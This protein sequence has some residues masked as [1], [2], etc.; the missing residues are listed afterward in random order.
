M[1]LNLY[2]YGVCDIGCKKPNNEDM[3]LLHDKMFRDGKLHLVFDAK[4]RLVFAVADGVGGL[5]KGEVASEL[6]LTSLRDILEKIPGDLS[7]E[8]LREVFNTY[9][10]ETHAK[11]NKD[12][13]ST[14]VGLFIYNDKLFRF[15]AGDSRIYRLRRGELERLTVDHSLC[16]S[17]GQKDAPSNII[18]NSIGG[19]ASSFIEFAEIPFPFFNNDIYLLSSDGMHDLVSQEEITKVLSNSKNAAEKLVELAKK[20]GGKD[21]ISVVIINIKEK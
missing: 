17:G 1:K 4:K 13:G 19:G 15:H 18:T 20:Y 12:M 5:N 2:A 11:L 7:N 16:E 9:T 3:V 21:N 8:E 6:V 10:S 14:L